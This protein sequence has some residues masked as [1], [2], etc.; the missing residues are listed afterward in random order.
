MYMASLNSLKGV[1][2]QNYLLCR[3]CNGSKAIIFVII[4]L[5]GIEVVAL[6]VAV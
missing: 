1:Y 3:G 6:C 4:C 5:D 2:L